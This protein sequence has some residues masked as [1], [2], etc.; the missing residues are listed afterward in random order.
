MDKLNWQAE[1]VSDGKKVGKGGASWQIRSDDPPSTS[2]FAFNYG[3]QRCQVQIVA[4]GSPQTVEEKDKQQPKEYEAPKSWSEAVAP[5]VLQPKGFEEK[6]AGASIQ[7]DASMDLDEHMQ[8]QEDEHKNEEPPEQKRRK[9]EPAQQPEAETPP[10]QQQMTL[11]F[12]KMQQQE[13]TLASVVDFLKSWKQSAPTPLPIA[14]S[15][16]PPQEHLR[17]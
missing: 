10:L 4:A 6:P 14:P 15:C 7:Q 9:R 8:Q 11:L 16:I 12:A 1:V 17:E 13:E 5:R 3:Y 2:A